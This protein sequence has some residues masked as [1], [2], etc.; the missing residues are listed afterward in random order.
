MSEQSHPADHYERELQ[1][2]LEL[3]LKREQETAEFY[4]QNAAKPGA[5][6]EIKAMFELL[7]GE[8]DGHVAIITGRLVENRRRLAAIQF[9]GPYGVSRE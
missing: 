1:E 8:E 5:R 6:P 3:S 2:V 9:K 7:V 4:R